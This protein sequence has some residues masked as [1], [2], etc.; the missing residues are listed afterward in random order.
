MNRHLVSRARRTL[1]ALRFH[2]RI[3]TASD[4]VQLTL[5]A[6]ELE[7]LISACA[8]FDKP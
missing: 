1:R 8:A 5:L 7:A 2:A 3:G 6:D 4:R